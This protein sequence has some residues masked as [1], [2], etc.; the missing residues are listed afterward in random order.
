MK[1]KI[2]REL[3]KHF[4]AAVAYRTQKAVREAP[5][6]YWDFSAGNKSRTPAEMLRHMT[7]VLGYARTFMIG[8]QYPIH[9]DP[10]ANADEEINRFHEVLEDLGRLL[11]ESTPLRNINEQQLLQ[12]PLSDVMTHAGQLALLRRLHGSPVPPENFIFADIAPERLGRNQSAPRRPDKEW[13]EK[14]G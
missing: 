1:R 8:G 5:L 13:P 2:E 6:D 9:P 4:L 11:A 12:G 10:L 14:L 7:S 3:L